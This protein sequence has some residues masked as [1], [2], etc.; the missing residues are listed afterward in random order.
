MLLPH[1]EERTELGEPQPPSSP[2]SPFPRAP[3]FQVSP[4][5]SPPCSYSARLGFWV[6]I[7][8]SLPGV[9]V[10]HVCAF[11]PLPP[12]WEPLEKPDALIYL[13]CPFDPSNTPQYDN[14]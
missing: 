6:Y 5:P 7:Y 1:G 11:L 12:S 4:Q 3:S 9:K 2:H 14:S 13:S 8:H 10:T